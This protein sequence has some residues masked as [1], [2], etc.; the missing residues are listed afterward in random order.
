MARDDHELLLISSQ[1]FG[2][3]TAFEAFNSKHRGG[4]GVTAMKMRGG[5]GT[6]VRALAVL[7]DD[8]VMLIAR[9]G[10]II[11]I[12]VDDVSVQGPHASGVRVMSVPDDD[13]VAAVSL[14]REPESDDDE[15]DE[16]TGDTETGDEATNTADAADAEAPT[17][18]EQVDTEPTNEASAVDST[19][20]VI[21]DSNESESAPDD[22]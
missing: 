13:E 14:V 4:Q 10:I 2:K 8:E 7:P 20:S 17:G 12:S 3:R 22:E 9:S 1:G 15:A 6:V 18:T 19:E 21:E 16:A 11:R 5:T